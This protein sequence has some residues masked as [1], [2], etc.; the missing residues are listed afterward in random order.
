MPS[1]FSS[2]VVPSSSCPQ[3]LP[4]SGSFPMSQLF[5]WGG[6]STGVSTSASVLSMNTQDWSPLG[7]TCWISLQSKGLRRVFSSTTV[8]KH[9]FFGTQYASKF[10]KLSHSHRTGNGQ[11]LFQSLRREMPKN[12]Q[13]TIQLFSFH[14]LSHYSKVIDFL[15]DSIVKNLPAMQEIWVQSLGQENDLEKEMAAYCSILALKIPW[16]EEPPRL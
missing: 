6:Q 4:A 8:W 13:T 15:G 3:S 10:W 1:S 16:P 2:S 7:W 12:V 9:Q 11:F 5:T 14:M